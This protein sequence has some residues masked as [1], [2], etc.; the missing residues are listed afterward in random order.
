VIS[1]KIVHTPLVSEADFVAA[2]A[3]SAV[4]APEDGSTRTYLLVGLLRCRTC[5]RRMDSHWVHGRP[6][7]R[8]R[9]GH[10]SA[11]PAAPH[12]PKTLYLRE[13]RIVTRIAHQL[14]DLKPPGQAGHPVT[15]PDPGEIAQFLQA[16]NMMITCDAE[17]C[18]LDADATSASPTQLAMIT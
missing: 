2:Q 5:R 17:T 10:T 12:R 3:I 13:D 14:H 1:T 18:A 6:G 9:H 7:Y 8:C 11:K 4:S 16:S 15:K